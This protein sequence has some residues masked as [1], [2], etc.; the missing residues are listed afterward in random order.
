MVPCGI[1]LILKLFAIVVIYA[2]FEQLFSRPALFY[3]DLAGY[4]DCRPNTPNILYS[5]S[6][7]LLNIS[8]LED[9]QALTL[10]LLLNTAKD[11]AFI[12]IIYCL[13][14]RRI[15]M[16]FVILLSLH[17][18]LALYHPRYV[19]TVFSS[20]SLLLVFGYDAK[21][22]WLKNTFS[23]N[24]VLVIASLILVGLRY[25]NSII[26]ILYF[27]FKNYRNFYLVGSLFIFVLTLI[28]FSWTYAYSFIDYSINAQGYILS[29]DKIFTMVK[30]TN[31]AAINYFLATCLYLLSHL[32]ALTGFREAAVLDFSGYFFPMGVKSAAQFILFFTFSLFHIFGIIAF[33]VYFWQHKGI[34]FCVITNILIC[35]LF[36]THIR[37]F[38]HLIPLALL[39]WSVFI[40][41]N[42]FYKKN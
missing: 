28:L 6:I 26:F 5:Y 40:D 23:S 18:F 11:L 32:I 14:N 27:T 29:F 13:T 30:A 19:T 41:K 38:T 17:P 33:C 9:S 35:C 37:Y 12:I 39:G 3:G 15:C 1:Y 31:I 10:G 42:I 36:L 7:C 8:S 24:R 25:T 20:I 22:K 4:I 2:A 34:V 21:S 16:V